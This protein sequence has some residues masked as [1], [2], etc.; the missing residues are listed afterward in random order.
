MPLVVPGL[1]LHR[2]LELLVAAGLSPAEALRS[3]TSAA[4]RFLGEEGEFGVVEEGARADLLLLEENPLA[5]ISA[6]SSIRA[7]VARGRWI[8]P[9]RLV[10][11]RDSVR[12]ANRS[13]G[14]RASDLE[15]PTGPGRT[16]LE[17]T[18]VVHFAGRPVAAEQF[19][20][21]ETGSG[22]TVLVGR[23]VPSD[24]MEPA[25]HLRAEKRAGEPWHRLEVRAGRRA[26][27][28]LEPSSSGERTARSVGDR[29]G[30]QCGGRYGGGR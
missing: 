26:R 24:A 15:A 9:E 2:E 7:I 22:D 25:V 4:A 1:A 16:L 23:Q 6:T 28:A 17:R 10:A 11:T 30:R 21:F 8:P 14:T 3:A 18:F 19:A 13:L 29:S 5:D 27:M 12:Q 20:L